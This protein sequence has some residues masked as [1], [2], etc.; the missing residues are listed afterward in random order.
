MKYE[1]AAGS[2][3]ELMPIH[4]LL[5]LDAVARLGSVQAAA[6]AL[7]VTPSGISHR[8][9]SLET[10]L[11]TVL[12]ERKGRGVALTAEGQAC[13]QAV[14]RGLDDLA[15]ATEALRRNENDVVRIATASAIG[16][17]WLLPRLKQRAA[18]GANAPRIELLTLA[19]ADEL[20][21]DRW[22][23]LIHYGRGARRGNHRRLLFVD[24][25]V[26]VR[27]PNGRVRERSRNTSTGWEH[28]PTLRLAQLGA[29]EVDF[30]LGTPSVARGQLIFDDALAMLEAASTGAGTAIS[31]EAAAQPY[32]DS[33]RLVRATELTHP[34]ERYFADISENGRS[35][36]A[37]SALF[38]WLV[39]SAKVNEADA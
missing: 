6:D 27:A 14:Q 39:Q 34:G 33:G 38:Q 3:P 2:A 9:A 8:I 13:V 4:E 30:G 28:K 15:S 16:A 21:S 36:P 25:L 18:Q 23:I 17:A 19:T 37:A 29:T 11:D 24:R 5:A 22:D 26:A 12:L 7:H 31:T 20:P 35:K 1:H 32:L 10:R